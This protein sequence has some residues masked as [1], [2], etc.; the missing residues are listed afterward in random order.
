MSSEEEDSDENSREIDYP[1]SEDVYWSEEEAKN[2]QRRHSSS[3]TKRLLPPPLYAVPIQRLE[4]AICFDMLHQ[5]EASYCFAACGNMFHTECVSS[6]LTCPMCRVQARF[7]PLS[8][9]IHLVLENKCDSDF[10]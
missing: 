1:D 2:V 7:A 6:L 5:S 9:H 3:V 4:C 10:P 8:R